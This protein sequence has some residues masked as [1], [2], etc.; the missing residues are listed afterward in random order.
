MQSLPLL[1]NFSSSDRWSQLSFREVSELSLAEEMFEV[2]SAPYLRCWGSSKVLVVASLESHLN[3]IM[4][5]V[6]TNH[7]TVTR[8]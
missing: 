3:M 1:V 7:G 5:S 6:D 8:C 4:S 2:K